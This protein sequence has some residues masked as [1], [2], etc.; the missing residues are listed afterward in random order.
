[1]ISI[2]VVGYGFVGKAV[3]QL[4]KLYEVNIYDPYIPE[5][6]GVE[7]QDAAYLSDFVFLCVPTPTEEEGNYLDISNVENSA[8]L[9]AWYNK[10]GKQGGP[11]P[12]SILVVKST[13]NV[14]TVENLCSFLDT[15]RIVHN[16]EFLSQRTAME[17]FLN[18][19]EVIVGG[20]TEY[21][22]E[23]VNMLMEF[24]SFMSKEGITPFVVPS[25]MAELVKMTRNSFYATK[26]SFFNEV[27]DLCQELEIN[28]ADFRR[29]FTLSGN[30]PWIAEQHTQVPGPDGM[31]G[32]GGACLPKDAR[33]LLEYA[34]S[35]G[36]DMNILRAA[37][38][39]NNRRRTDEDE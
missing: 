18:P 36:I 27:Y 17:D 35:L 22:L 4:D 12:K 37:I 38:D 11:N 31:V 14:G 3:S 13:V 33:G 19:T 29:V 16:P 8:R 20:K 6:R 24:Y 15:E 5:Y 1:M 2:G 39:T 34:E 30:H 26:V 9:W 21:A 7:K 23:V 28:Y 25:N 10:R 32:Y